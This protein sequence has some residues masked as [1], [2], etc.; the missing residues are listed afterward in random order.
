M[1]G[2]VMIF[3]AIGSNLPDPQYGPPVEVCNAAVDAIEACGCRIL[4]KS[5]WFRSAPVPVSDQPDFVN[6]VVSVQTSLEPA[7]LLSRLHAIEARFD[8]VRSVPNAARTLD[9]DLI[10]YGDMVNDDPEG[11]L[12]P[13]P[14]MAGRGFVLLPLRDVAP[15][16]IHP[17]LGD[18]LPVLIAALPDDQ[19]CIPID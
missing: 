18:T 2:F 6:G 11:P 17:V 5:R 19:I 9:L 16:W 10:A 14:R 7:A 1:F 12:L 13:H 15:A 3:I 4:A 8:R